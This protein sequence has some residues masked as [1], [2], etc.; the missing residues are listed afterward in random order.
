MR[1]DQK[2][3]KGKKK[4][5]K[6]CSLE[7][8][9]LLLVEFRIL[10]ALYLPFF[11]A[12]EIDV[13]MPLSMDRNTCWMHMPFEP[14]GNQVPSIWFQVIFFFCFYSPREG[15]PFLK[16]MCPLENRACCISDVFFFFQK[17]AAHDVLMRK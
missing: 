1:L 11:Y 16:A 5:K 6:T 9:S 7:A 10:D 8:N 3:K 15:F 4:R 14:T 12:R 2:T 13:Y 17:S